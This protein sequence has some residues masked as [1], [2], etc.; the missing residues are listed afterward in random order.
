MG[1]LRLWRRLKRLFLSRRKDLDLAGLPAGSCVGLLLNG[2]L[3]YATQGQSLQAAVE[4]LE[5]QQAGRL[6]QAH[7][8]EEG[9]LPLAQGVD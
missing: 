6:P 7:G 3:G 8:E 1:S 5:G 2:A 9:L 4:Q